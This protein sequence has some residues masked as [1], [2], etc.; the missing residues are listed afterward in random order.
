MPTRKAPCN[1]SG[2]VRDG[3]LFLESRCVREGISL[4]RRLEERL[5]EITADASQLHQVLVNLVV[6][7]IQ[8][9]PHGGTLTIETRAEGDRILLTVE[10]TGVGMTDE[11]LKQLF[12]PF[13]TTK[14][15]GQG[16]G[17]GLSVVHGIVSSHGGTIRVESKP[18][19][20]SRFVVTL[21]AGNASTSKENT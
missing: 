12:L 10:D 1:L 19:R 17:L 16:T 13:F 2:L 4:V 21:P 3:L 9:M 8:A 20:G 7:A 18:G 15:I 14:D 11:V 6:N 5:P